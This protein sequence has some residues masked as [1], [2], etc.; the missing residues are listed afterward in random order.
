ALATPAEQTSLHIGLADL[1]RRRLA[2][3][4]DNERPNYADLMVAEIKQAL[5]LL[6]DN[7]DRVIEL[8]QWQLDGMQLQLNE[9]RNQRDWPAALAIV[10]QMA[11]LPAEVIDP[12]L[13]AEDRRFILIQQA[14]ELMEQ[15][16]RV[17]ALAV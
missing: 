9:T 10:E 8:R 14:L 2:E 13:V 5:V 17:A 11:L 6:P 3:V 12:N 1:Y 15:G 4:G 16:N 7:D